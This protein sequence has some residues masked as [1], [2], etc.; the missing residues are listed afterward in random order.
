MKKLSIFTALLLTAFLFTGCSSF[1]GEPDCGGEVP[2]VLR[3][4]SLEELRIL[5]TLIDGAPQ[6]LED[7]YNEDIWSLDCGNVEQVVELFG[8]MENVVIPYPKKSENMEVTYIHYSSLHDGADIW[9]KKGKILFTAK[10]WPYN[11]INVYDMW[12]EGY[13]N[14]EAVYQWNIAGT[15]YPVYQSN[16]ERDFEFYRSYIFLEN[17]QIVF[18]IDKARDEEKD[19]FYD[20]SYED[21]D[22]SDLE[23]FEFLTV[24]EV[25]DRME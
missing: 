2:S 14:R 11:E 1:V 20:A 16:H 19:D 15:E 25:L 23:N 18:T 9:Y 10:V 6:A 4:Q 22:L 7:Y 5:D 3:F 12:S 13:R 21:V 24:K 17:Y 8:R